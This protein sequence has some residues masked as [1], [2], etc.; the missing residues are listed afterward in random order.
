MEF[1]AGGMGKGDGSSMTPTNSSGESRNHK[2]LHSHRATDVPRPCLMP[3]FNSCDQVIIK[4][5][6]FWHC[7]G[8]DVEP[9]CSSQT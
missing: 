2:T 9:V 1:G 8:K 4:H 3:G 6:S 7:Y 5:H